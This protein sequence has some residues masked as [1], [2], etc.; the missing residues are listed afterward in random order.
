MLF[1][2]LL[3]DIIARAENL[4]E[5]MAH[6][7]VLF[8]PS[9]LITSARFILMN[10]DNTDPSLRSAWRNI[11][12]VTPPEFWDPYRGDQELRDDLQRW[13]GRFAPP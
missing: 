4:P 10:L 6:E 5:P 9:T 11:V 8:R 12:R 2:A 7:P 1:P 3:E 13:L